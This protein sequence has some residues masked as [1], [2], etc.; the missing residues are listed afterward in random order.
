M[1]KASVSRNYRFPTLN[2]LYF[3]PGGNPNL[4]NEHGF[5]YDAGV[6]FE[7]GKENAY[8]L[9]GGANWFDSYIDDCRIIWLPTTK[10]FFSP[11][12]VKKVHAYG[13][14]VKANLAVQPAKDWLIDL[15]GSFVD[16]S[17]TGARKCHLLTSRWANSYL[18][19]G[20]FRLADRTVVVAVVGVP[21][22]VGVLLGAFHHVEQRLYATGHLPEYF[23]SSVS[24]RK[25]LFQTGD[26]Q[27][28]F[29]INNLSNEDYLGTPARACMASTS[30][31]S[32]VSPR[33]S[34][35]KQEK[36][37]KHKFVMI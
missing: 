35:E 37:R 36:V 22:Q 15:N 18:R 27:L 9:S 7:V 2:D 26:V 33:S 12:N 14:E 10:G 8:K 16:T 21:L 13:I 3:L 1:L 6:S 32:S 17:S 34:W 25:P 20:A 11:R 31:C 30:S 5:S 23:M 29:A 4:R 28:K 24:W 19:A